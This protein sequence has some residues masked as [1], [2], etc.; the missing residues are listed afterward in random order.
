MKLT[1]MTFPEARPID[2]Y[3]PGFFRVGGEVVE[4]AVIVHSGGVMHWGGLED[5]A[6]AL[7]L[8]NEIDVLLLG[9]GAEMATPPAEFR[10]ALEEAGV[11]LEPMQSASACRTYNILLS[12]GRR[13]A[14]ALLPI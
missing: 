11:G 5:S 3:G 12:E 8:A 4:G 2:G 13:V 7:R 6:S 1:E 14:A 10:A 9:T